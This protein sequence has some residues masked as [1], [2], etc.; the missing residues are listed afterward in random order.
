MYS[1]QRPRRV[2]L[3]TSEEDDAKQRL[4]ILQVHDCGCHVFLWADKAKKVDVEMKEKKA[5]ACFSDVGSSNIKDEEVGKHNYDVTL[6]MMTVMFE[7]P[8]AMANN[9]SRALDMKMRKFSYEVFQIKVFK[10]C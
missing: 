5:W 4:V 6:M 1:M 8:V 7:K 2:G 3:R 10:V 9:T